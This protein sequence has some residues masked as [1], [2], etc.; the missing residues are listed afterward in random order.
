MD[1]SRKK[2][3]DLMKF[4]KKFKYIHVILIIYFLINLFFLTG[5]PFIHSDEAWLSGLSRTILREGSYNVTEP[6]FDLYP[7]SPHAIRSIFNSIQIIFLNIFGYQIFTF[8]LI[9]L[10][11]G[12]LSLY[13]FYKLAIFCTSSIKLS[14]LITIL[15]AVDIQFI[16]ASHI[17]RQ[18]ILL[19]FIFIIS[20]YLFLTKLLQENSNINNFIL[21]LLIIIAIGIHPNSFIIF[22]PL[23]FTY[24]YYILFTNKLS[25]KDLIIFIIT[26]AA[27]ALFFFLL[28]LY[29]DPNFVTN[30]SEYGETLGVFTSIQTKFDRLDYFYQKLYYQVSG[31]YFTPDIKPQFYLFGITLIYTIYKTIFKNDYINNTLLISFLAIN[32]GY[33]LIGRYN[34]TS[35]IFIF[36]ILYLLILNSFKSID[37]NYSKTIIT[38][39]I[40]LISLNSFFI[41]YDN[42]YFN[43]DDYLDEISTVV[44]KDDKVLANLNSHYYFD[45]NKLHDYRNLAYLSENNLSF[46]DYIEKNQIEYII[47]PEEMDFIYNTRPTWN[48]LYGN[49]YPYY[50]DMQ[51]F[52]ENNCTLVKEFNNITYGIR[53]AQYIGEKNWKV[54]IFKVKEP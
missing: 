15:M 39:L 29:F 42:T 52:L 5:F 41:I 35:I 17:A 22:L 54:K 32:I 13:Y 34:Q 16:Y 38:A 1:N 8:R 23:L 14:S 33:V 6:F 26:V 46:S 43:Y 9:S 47:Y 19:V 37:I 21:A 31:T 44:N 45:Y 18:E 53:I 2:G 28:S 36:P 25:W 40:I 11:F 24:L 3:F 7:R 20:L 27:G 49:I 4:P 30:Y 12:T 48:T 50:T 51:N 10:L